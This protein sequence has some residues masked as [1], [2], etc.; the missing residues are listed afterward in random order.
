MLASA[1]SKPKHEQDGDLLEVERVYG[2][3][4]NSNQKR[5]AKEFFRAPTF[6][7]WAKRN[8][9]FRLRQGDTEALLAFLR[10]VGLFERPGFGD[11]GSSASKTLLSSQDGSL[12]DVPYESKISEKHIWGIRR[13]IQGSLNALAQHTGALHDFHVR[14]EP[15][16]NGKSRLVFTTATF[17]DALLLTLS[18]DQVQG[19]KVR[20][21]ERPDCGISF[22]VTGRRKRKYCEW[23]CGHIESVR[24]QRRKNKR[25]QERGKR[26]LATKRDTKG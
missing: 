25:G 2:K 7:P 24:K 14:F 3:V 17:L 21:C 15:A 9:F 5:E 16:S 10:S 20:K 1:P 8:E 6:D 18:V 22:S 4:P 13:L 11:E 19:A 23:Y 26:T 12:H